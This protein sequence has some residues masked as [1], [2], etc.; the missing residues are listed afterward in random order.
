MALMHPGDL[1]AVVR[2]TLAPS[3]SLICENLR[4]LRIF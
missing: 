2:E 1:S 3:V 4:N